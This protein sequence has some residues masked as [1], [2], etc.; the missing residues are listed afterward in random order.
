MDLDRSFWLG[1]TGNRDRQFGI[2]SVPTWTRTGAS[3]LEPL[4]TLLSRHDQPLRKRIHDNILTTAVN[5]GTEIDEEEV[6]CRMYL[7]DSRGRT[8]AFTITETDIIHHVWD[9]GLSGVADKRHMGK[10]IL[11]YALARGAIARSDKITRK[12]AN[13]YRTYHEMK[14][15]FEDYEQDV[16]ALA[17]HLSGLLDS[18]KNRTCAWDAM[19]EHGFYPE[20]DGGGVGEE[21]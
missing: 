10:L 1:S 12:V 13:I 8:Y 21:L 4:L 16:P 7:E 11:E 6:K 14:E 18:F 15:M 9:H 19:A 2:G 5:E 20:D 3:S 17:T